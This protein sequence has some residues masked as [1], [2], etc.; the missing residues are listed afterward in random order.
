MQA[1]LLSRRKKGSGVMNL[2]TLPIAGVYVKHTFDVVYVH[3]D[4]AFYAMPL[5]CCMHN[6][7]MAMFSQWPLFPH[8]A[9]L[10]S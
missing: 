10:S 8:L 2:S 7:A 4:M 3:D 1:S 5:L 9:V 6:L